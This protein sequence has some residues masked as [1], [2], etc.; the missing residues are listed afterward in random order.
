M[1]KNSAHNIICTRCPSP[2]VRGTE[3]PLCARCLREDMQKTASA[4]EET[5]RHIVECAP[6]KLHR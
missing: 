3:P 2:A 1:E 5:L 6:E 4:R